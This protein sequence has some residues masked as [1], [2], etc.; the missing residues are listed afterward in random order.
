MSLDISGRGA[1]VVCGK[2]EENN[3]WKEGDGEL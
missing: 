3:Q 2:E 1:V